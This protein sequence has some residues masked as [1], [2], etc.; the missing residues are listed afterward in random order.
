[1]LSITVGPP[2]PEAAVETRTR[3]GQ[4][5]ALR[6]IAAVAVA[7]FHFSC[8]SSA[9]TTMPMVRASGAYGWVGVEMFFVISGFII[10]Y[11]LAS[12]SYAISRFPTFMAR[13]LMRLEPPYFVSIALVIALAF[14]SAQ[15]TAFRGPA[16]NYTLEQIGLHVA[17]LISFFGE[18]WINPVYWSLAIEFQFYLLVG[19][20]FPLI[21]STRTV[22]RILLAA[23]CIGGPVLSTNDRL[24]PHWLPIFFVGFL[25]FYS[26]QASRTDILALASFA[27]AGVSVV[28]HF[29]IPVAIAVTISALLMRAPVKFPRW[30][31]WI[32]GISYSIYLLHVPLGGRVINLATRL[33]EGAVRLPALALAMAFTVVA[34]YL[35]YRAIELPAQHWSQRIGESRDRGQRRTM[36]GVESLGSVSRAG[37]NSAG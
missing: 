17:Y 26:S 1:M 25:L 37:G 9:F 20:L 8:G 30:L 2:S 18:G 15:F 11:S 29:G 10:P 27:L 36:E 22:S 33:P 7:W 16:P 12:K 14:A 3:L 13:R 28:W 19:L 21:A 23:V 5:D 24:L 34:S 35:F 6:G 4:I 31:I 32:G